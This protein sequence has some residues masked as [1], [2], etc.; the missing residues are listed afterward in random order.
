VQRK[1]NTLNIRFYTEQNR[2]AWNEIAKPRRAKCK[3]P[4]FFVSGKSTLSEIELREAGNVQGKRLL[5]LQSASG[6]E[7][8][9]WAVHGAQVTAVDISE[10]AV[11]IGRDQ[12]KRAGL[13]VKFVVADVYELP[14]ELQQQD[15]DIVY[16]S[17]GITCWLPDIQAWARIVSEA[18]RPGGKL[19]L[20][21]IH[22]VNGCLWFKDGSIEV[23]RDYFSRKE[24]YRSEGG[25]GR[26]ACN[27]PS[28]ETHYEFSWP[29]GDIVTAVVRA[30]MR[31]DSL[32]EFPGP[33]A[34]YQKEAE[35]I[36]VHPLAE[37]LPTSYLLSATRER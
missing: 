22:P 32:E 6:N 20:Y 8:L 1:E 34:Y 23:D 11:D 4:E 10:I 26:L 12:A 29:L 35:N 18:L 28:A 16:S 25:L 27:A 15:F 19:L 7:A 24:P 37:R 9:S 21:D 13:D 3:P 31:I 36:R 17:A 14:V 5:N 33:P 2:L 30:G